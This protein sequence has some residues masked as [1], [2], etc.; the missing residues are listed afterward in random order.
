MALSEKALDLITEQ[1]AEIER[2]KADN[3][4]LEMWNECYAEERKQGYKQAKIE[5][6]EELRRRIVADKQSN[7]NVVIVAEYEIYKLIEEVKAE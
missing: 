2:L 1:E 5:V 7:D 3:Q 4:A 6:L